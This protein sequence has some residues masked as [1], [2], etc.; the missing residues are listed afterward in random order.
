MCEK[1][2]KTGSRRW[3]QPAS[4]RRG[5]TGWFPLY[6]FGILRAL[7]SVINLKGKLGGRGVA[8]LYRSILVKISHL[9][10]VF[11]A[12]RSVGFVRP[13][14]VGRTWRRS[15]GE[16]GTLRSPSPHC[17]HMKVLISV[18]WWSVRLKLFVCLCIS[19]FVFLCI[20]FVIC[21]LILFSVYVENILHKLTFDS[22]YG[23]L[24]WLGVFWRDFKFLIV[25]YLLRRLLNFVMS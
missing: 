23:A 4:G 1:N 2:I 12:V 8:R 25:K 14:C 11:V 6:P 20:S 7:F 24:F 16:V 17:C 5:S 9:Q 13:V 10:T 3:E 18:P 19:F 22:S 21:Q 15:E